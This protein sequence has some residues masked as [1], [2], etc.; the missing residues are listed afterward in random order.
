[1]QKCRAFGNNKF[2]VTGIIKE[3][4]FKKWV[5]SSYSVGGMTKAVQDIFPE[6]NKKYVCNIF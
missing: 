6:S 5:A 2:G 1:M 4:S 3:S